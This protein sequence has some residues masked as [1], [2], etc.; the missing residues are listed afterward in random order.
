MLPCLIVAD[1]RH[2]QHN[3]TMNVPMTDAKTIEKNE[4]QKKK[5]GKRVI[6]LLK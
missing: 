1:E 6:D 2:T 3:R 4:L 5:K